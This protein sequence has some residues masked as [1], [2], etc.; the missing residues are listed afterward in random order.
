M[1]GGGDDPAAGPSNQQEEMKF[2]AT[3]SVGIAGKACVAGDVVEVPEKDRAYLLASGDIVPAG[4]GV[5]TASAKPEAE[6]ASV[7]TAK[8]AAKKIARNK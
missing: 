4:S 1:A 7:N 3:R 6:T 8:K 5:E 2:K